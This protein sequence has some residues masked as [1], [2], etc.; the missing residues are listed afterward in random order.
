MWAGLLGGHSAEDSGE[1]NTSCPAVR[2][3]E[4]AWEGS[5]KS[6][7]IDGFGQGSR[8]TTVSLVAFDTGA[9][10][11]AVGVAAGG[12]DLHTTGAPHAT[13]GKNA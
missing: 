4:Q 11:G 1:E 10:D 3:A 8:V 5:D 6:V 9:L 2:D 13:I 7:F 12:L